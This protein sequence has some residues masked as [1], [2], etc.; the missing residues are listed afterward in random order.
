M[1]L[2][3]LLVEGVVV[4]QNADETRAE[5]VHVVA[6]TIRARLSDGEQPTDE[7]V[8]RWAV[9]ALMEWPGLPDLCLGSDPRRSA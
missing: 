1:A 6:S 5:A 2:L 4:T 7:N 8:A 9:D 3:R